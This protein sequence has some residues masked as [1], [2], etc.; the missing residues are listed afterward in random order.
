M[1]KCIPSITYTVT[2][3]I[4]W[5]KIVSAFQLY[6][7]FILYDIKFSYAFFEQWSYHLQCHRHLGLKSF[8]VKHRIYVRNFINNTKSG[9]NPLSMPRN[10]ANITHHY[11]Q[12]LPS[13]HSWVTSNSHFHHKHVAVFL[14]ITVHLI[15]LPDWI[16][17][18]TDHGGWCVK[19]EGVCWHFNHRYTHILKLLLYYRKP[20]LTWSCGYAVLLTDLVLD[21]EWIK[22]NSGLDLLQFMPGVLLLTWFNI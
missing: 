19:N 17:Y 4:L 9:K 1:C 7:H 22:M 8:E 14:Q 10:F 3:G 6:E 15:L 18:S 11:Q 2:T 20:H 12:L 16:Y 13:T 21:T 5:Y